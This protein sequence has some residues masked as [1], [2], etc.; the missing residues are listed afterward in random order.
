MNGRVEGV[1][2]HN[3]LS[4]PLTMRQSAGRAEQHEQLARVP[5]RG[6]LGPAALIPLERQAIVADNVFEGIGKCGGIAVNHGSSQ[7]VIA[8]N[9][10]I[11]YNGPAITASSY[12]VPTSFPSNTVTIKGNIIDM[13]YAGEKPA[14]ARRHHGQLFRSLRRAPDASTVAE[15]V[16]EFILPVALRQSWYAASVLAAIP[17]VGSEGQAGCAE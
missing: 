4:G 3:A 15:E 6:R 9:L 1:G 14:A 5:H 12:T 2:T 7:M 10:F 17:G 16:T 11:N 8:N 13:T